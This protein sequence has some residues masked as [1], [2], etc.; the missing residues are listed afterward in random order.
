[1]LERVRRAVARDLANEYGFEYEDTLLWM[2]EVGV[3][4]NWT[5]DELLHRPIDL[6]ELADCIGWDGWSRPAKRVV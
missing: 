2:Q 6:A 4:G 5:E 3:F 1:M